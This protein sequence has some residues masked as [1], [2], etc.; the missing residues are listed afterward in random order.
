MKKIITLF[1]ALTT[2]AYAQEPIDEHYTPEEM[3]ASR[4]M[5]K[6]MHGATNHLFLIADK[7]EY[8]NVDGGVLAWE[9]KGLYGGDHEKLY[10]KSEAEFG[11]S[12]DEFH[13]GDIE[14]GYSRA[15]VPF[16]DFQAG[17]MHDFSAGPKRTYG[18]IGVMGLAPY[19]FEIDGNL[20]VSDKGD[21]AANFEVEYELLLTQR[22]ILQPIVELNFQFQDVPEL[23]IGSGFS[24]LE[25]GLRLRYEIKRE[26]APYVGVHWH[27]SFG[28]TADYQRAEGEGT[29]EVSIVAGVRFWY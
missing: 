15:I 12:E 22:M 3:A 13:E 19:W 10:F 2:F 24:E 20:E 6:K 25:A 17:I 5:L 23:G 8:R 27:Q 1:L 21:V 26:F 9:A 28:G 14:A 18:T 7:F 4:M 16:F 29:S 11:F